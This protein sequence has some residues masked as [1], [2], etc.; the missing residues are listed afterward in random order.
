MLA[1]I[2]FNQSTLAVNV[3]GMA[4]SG[5]RTLRSSTC[6]LILLL[7]FKLGNSFESKERFNATDKL[8]V[9]FFLLLSV[10]GLCHHQQAS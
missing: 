5:K 2:E 6:R 3:V 4:V 8:P 1:P 10:Q 9:A 7:I